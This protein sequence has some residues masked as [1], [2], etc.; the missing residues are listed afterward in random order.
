MCTYLN[1]F[2]R[3]DKV[4]VNNTLEMKEIKILSN[5]VNLLRKENSNK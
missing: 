1:K 5:K 2:L 4:S 3:N